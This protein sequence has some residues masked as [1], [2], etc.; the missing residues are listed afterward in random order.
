MSFIEKLGKK[1]TDAGQGI[2]QQTRNLADTARLNAS[3]ND[4]KK[5]VSAGYASLGQAYYLR[6]MRDPECEFWSEVDGLNRLFEQIRSAEEEI[7]QIRGVTA[8]EKCGADIPAGAAFCSACGTPAPKPAP[9]GN[10]FCTSCG[11][12]LDDGEQEGES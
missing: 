10:R 4:R 1:L 11:A 6:H 8:C 3:I 5:Q 9:E 2:S 7:R 12:K